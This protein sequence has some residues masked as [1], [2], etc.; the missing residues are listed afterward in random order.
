MKLLWVTPCRP[1]LFPKLMPMLVSA[2]GMKPKLIR[3]SDKAAAS[4]GLEF[5]RSYSWG[6]QD[7]MS[8][9]VERDED[10]SDDRMDV[11]L[12]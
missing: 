7:W 9:R 8:V 4:V 10:V 1:E 5:G 2:H 6:T 11:I 12:E 3:I